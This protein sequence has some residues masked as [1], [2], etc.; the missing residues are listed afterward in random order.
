MVYISGNGSFTTNSLITVSSDTDDNQGR[1]VLMHLAPYDK[2]F[3]ANM[4][5]SIL[6]F[7]DPNQ[8]PSDNVA[9]PSN[10]VG[11]IRYI[12][13][14]PFGQGIAISPDP[15][16]N[17]G[18]FLNTVGVGTWRSEYDSARATKVTLNA[19][20]DGPGRHSLQVGYG[21]IS[22]HQTMAS[23]DEKGF[24][25]V[26][27]PS[28]YTSNGS[29]YVGQVSTNP[30]KL[31]DP[32][33]SY[34][35]P[36]WSLGSKISNQMIENEPPGGYE[37]DELIPGNIAL[38]WDTR[39]R[40][41]ING[42]N[43]DSAFNVFGNIRIQADELSSHTPNVDYGAGIVFPDGTYQYT[44]W[45]GS[46]NIG[47]GGSNVII[48]DESVVLTNA[49]T[50]INFV[51][52][53]ITANA[54][55]SNVTVTVTR[56]G[57]QGPQGPTGPQGAQGPQGPSGPSVTGPQ[58]PTGPTGP[59]SND[60]YANIGTISGSTTLNRNTASIQRATATDSFALTVP[61]NFTV[62]QSLTLIVE[63]GGS[64]NCIASYDAA[65]KF[66]SNYKTLSTTVG[67]IDMI[68]MFYD[69]TTVFCTLT[70]GYV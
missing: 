52:N 63:Q 42:A 62:G 33:T 41:S 44:A 30:Y 19:T 66:A 7:V 29:M 67:S 2:G 58:G 61:S 15:N 24:S 11:S 9:Y 54:S 4:G 28:I 26:I 6:Y 32:N 14:N 59:A 43:L 1:S 65:Y 3:G 69:G 37:A 46:G 22:F 31:V 40:V 35:I 17:D 27:I 50:K 25:Y 55:G 70:T 36:T 57:V 53:G 8:S 39:S 68:N 49:V 38:T 23:G 5:Q 13:D 18:S 48:A 16:Y 21:A 56:M 47:G 34:H 10:R 12:K 60:S 51:G 20:A 45:S 64:G